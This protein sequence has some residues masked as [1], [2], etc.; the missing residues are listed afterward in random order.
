VLAA[1]ADVAYVTGFE[2]DTPEELIRKVAPDVLVKG[3]DW[4]GKEVAGQRFVES[5]G[6]K[7]VFAPLV[8]GVSTTN[9]IAKANDKGSG[10]KQKTT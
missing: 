9:L 6:G 7:V 1:L 2:D 10:R 5:K 8:Q 3:A 4:E